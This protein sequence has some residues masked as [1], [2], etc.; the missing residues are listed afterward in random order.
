[1]SEYARTPMNNVKTISSD[2]TTKSSL[3]RPP[4]TPSHQVR[5]PVYKLKSAIELG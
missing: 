4:L 1:M 3:L 2:I 5:L